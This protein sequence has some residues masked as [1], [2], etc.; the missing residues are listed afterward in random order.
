MSFHKNLRGRDLH[1]PSSE[2][3]EN[4]TG[5][6]L[7]KL[8]VVDLNGMGT[9]YPQI[10]IGNPSVL[11]NFGVVQ[12]DILT[13]KYG[14]I[15]CLGF[16]FEVDTSLW[17]VGT[18]L[19][20][21]ALGQLQ[22]TIN[23]S[24]IAIVV[25]QD[26]TYGVLYITADLADQTSS[27]EWLVNGNTGLDALVNFIGT[28]DNIP[29]NFRTNNNQVGK[30]D[31]N[32][33]FAIGSHAPQSPFHI[34]TT[35]GYTGSG[36]QLDQFSMTSNMN[37]LVNAYS[38]NM[39]NGQIIRVKFQVTARQ[40]DGTK[41]ASFT[42]SALFY[43]E[44]GNVAIQGPTWASDFTAKSDNLFDISYQLG[45]NYINFK[46]KNAA[47]VDTYWSGHV[48]MELIADVT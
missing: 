20:S 45:T 26:A 44:G 5:S 10:K 13:G 12:E 46:V 38:I 47:N 27:G 19:Y 18:I 23:G 29:L 4:N 22:S 30:F 1:A 32:G 37:T 36:Y 25:K 2:L 28:T 40:S 9:V 21:S 24:P 42:R 48:E 39:V 3:V 34:K 11:P 15:T 31:A 33:R 43:K 35:P 17:P 41:R 6:T 16:M 7:T 14:Y 8:S